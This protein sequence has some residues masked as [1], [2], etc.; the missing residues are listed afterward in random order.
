[1]R[2]EGLI[3]EPRFPRFQRVLD[4]FLDLPAK[5]RYPVA[6]FA[7]VAV[8]Y[9]PVGFVLAGTRGSIA[10]MAE[11]VARAVVW[12]QTTLGGVSAKADVEPYTRA[13]RTVTHAAAEIAAPIVASLL[14][15]TL[16]GVVAFTAARFVRRKKTSGH[17]LFS[18]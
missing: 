9:I 16:V 6:A 10:G 3:H 1:L 5:V 15:V 17:A 4:A 12:F 18:I 14:V 7:A 13:A 8:M 2:A 11:R